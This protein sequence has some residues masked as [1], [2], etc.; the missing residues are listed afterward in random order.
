ME[1]ARLIDVLK[2]RYNYRKQQEIS[3]IF[4]VVDGE[5]DIDFDNLKLITDIDT[6]KNTS[7]IVIVTLEKYSQNIENVIETH[8][9][10]FGDQNTYNIDGKLY[11]TVVTEL[12]KS[13][14]NN[15]ENSSNLELLDNI[16]FYEVL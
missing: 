13:L 1:A 15:L 2:S 9:I 10:K 11:I 4:P 8:T 6:L 14:I 3:K 7:P 5:V 12:D 16:S